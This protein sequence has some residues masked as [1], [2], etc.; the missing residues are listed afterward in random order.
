MKV[1]VLRKGESIKEV[2]VGFSW[3]FFF[4][5][6]F[7]PLFRNNLNDA[8]LTFLAGWF[9]LGLSHFYFMFKINERQKKYLHQLHGLLILQE[10][11]KCH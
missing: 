5:G 7:V 8:L 9:T 2:K 1:E 3:T 4:F 10:L 11:H 6:F